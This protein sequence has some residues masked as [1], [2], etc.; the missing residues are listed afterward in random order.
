MAALAAAVLL[1]GCTAVVPAGPAPSLK[2]T[3]WVVTQIHGE[4]TIADFQ[5]TMSFGAAN[6]VSGNTGCNQFSGSYTLTGTT[7]SFGPLAQ[8]EMACLDGGVM[9][10]EAA[11]GAALGTV[12]A[13]R[14]ADDTV[15]LLD[16]EGEVALLLA[17]VPPLDLAGTAWR[18][19]GLID[20]SSS[21]APVPDSSVTL[22]FT[23]DALSGKACNTFNG[24]YTLDGDSIRIGPLMSTRMACL[25]EELTAQETLVLELLQAATTATVNRG[26][27]TLTAADGRGLQFDKA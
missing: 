15:E 23:A 18:L 5:P 21:S 7:L 22:T 24:S 19:G 17:P 4:A 26:V 2:E 13:L 12:V 9:E 27:L 14:L 1:A 25:N 6:E 16:G 3:T 20:G 10:Q 8:T 11:F